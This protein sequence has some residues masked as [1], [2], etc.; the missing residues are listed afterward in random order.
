[1]GDLEGKYWLI[2][3]RR[4]AVHNVLLLKISG[5]NFDLR[6]TKDE[7]PARPGGSAVDTPP[8][9]EYSSCALFST[10]QL[11]WILVKTKIRGGRRA[12]NPK[13]GGPE[14]SPLT[15]N[16][17]GLSS[18]AD[19]W[20][21]WGEWLR[22]HSCKHENIRKLIWPLKYPCCSTDSKIVF[23]TIR[24]SLKIPILSIPVVNK[25]LLSFSHYQI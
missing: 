19:S 7:Y 9:S 5:I 13:H 25:D 15:L 20:H 23:Y 18:G 3:L 8:P 12:V 16:F 2:S 11:V 17:A 10:F 1:M 24:S 21:T 4:Y 22:G 6:H 14:L